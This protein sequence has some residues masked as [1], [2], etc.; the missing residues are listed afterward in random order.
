MS[1]EQSSFENDPVLSCTT[2]RFSCPD[3]LLPIDFHKPSLRLTA[4]LYA[5]ERERLFDWFAARLPE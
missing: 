2:K 3:I 1:N 4:A 5:A